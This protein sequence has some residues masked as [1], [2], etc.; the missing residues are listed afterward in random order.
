MAKT[1]DDLLMLKIQTRSLLKATIADR[2]QRKA[3]EAILDVIFAVY[4]T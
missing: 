2:E 1:R 3:A 4:G